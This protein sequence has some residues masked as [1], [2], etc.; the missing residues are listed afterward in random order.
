MEV[1]AQPVNMKVFLFIIITLLLIG[2]FIWLIWCEEKKLRM[3]RVSFMEGFDLTGLPI[4][5]LQNNGKK[6]NFV[7]DT[8]SYN[9]ILNK[10]ALSKITHKESDM[11]AHVC[12]IDGITRE[13]QTVVHT[14]F[15]Y[16]DKTIPA[17]LIVSDLSK[18]FAE[19]KQETGVQLHGLLGSDFFHEN[20]YIIDYKEMVAYSKKI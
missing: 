14:E 9:S 8:G 4:V 7:L 19:I 16:K 10:S 1:L 18:V 6:F 15:Q 13:D 2:L 11:V 3:H 12:G 20:K 5:T 17:R